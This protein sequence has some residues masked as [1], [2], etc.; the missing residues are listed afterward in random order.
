VSSPHPEPKTRFLLLSENCERRGRVRRLQSL[1]VLA[2]TFILWSEFHVTHYQIRNYPNL[3]GQVP[4]F[5]SHRNWVAQLYS[6]HWVRFSSPPTTSRDT[7]E[8]FET[9][10]TRGYLPFNSKSKSELLYDLRF[11]ANQFVL[12]PSPLMLTT[13]E[14]FLQLNPC[15]HSPH[16]TSS[17]TRG[18]V[19]LNTVGLLSSVRIAHIHVL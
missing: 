11:T 9:A 19:C 12:A 5:I 18:W 10:S 14:F 17:V 15:G 2:S 6:R 7:V 3:E 4:L 8:V 1:L 16:I 13:R